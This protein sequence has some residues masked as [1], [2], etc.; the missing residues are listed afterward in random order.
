MAAQNCTFNY[1]LFRNV[2]DNQIV[3]VHVD[4]CIVKNDNV[5]CTSDG[6]DFNGVLLTIGKFEKYSAAIIR[7]L[8][9]DLF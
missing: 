2:V 1:V 4:K 3:M 9:Y 5:T 8:I 7:L 6:K